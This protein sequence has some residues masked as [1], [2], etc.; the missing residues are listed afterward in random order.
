MTKDGFTGESVSSEE[1]T[2]LIK[3]GLNAQ[4]TMLTAPRSVTASTI[5][6]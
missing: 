5:T 2:N 4:K 6:N 3:L 1:T